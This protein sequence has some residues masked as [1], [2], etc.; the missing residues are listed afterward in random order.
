MIYVFLD[1][2]SGEVVDVEMHHT[3]VCEIAAVIEHEGRRLKRLVTMP[4]VRCPAPRKFVD[5]TLPYNYKYHEATGGTFDDK[6]RCQFESTRQMRN[7]ESMANDHGEGIEYTGGG[8]KP[9][10]KQK[11]ARP[12]RR[13]V[14]K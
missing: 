9:L 2:D 8:V 11:D 13:S 4:E 6:G 3:E 14:V 1:L 5:H 7:L 12:N 10:V